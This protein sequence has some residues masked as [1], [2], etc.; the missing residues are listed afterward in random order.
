MGPCQVSAEIA[1]YLLVI[2]IYKYF[3]LSLSVTVVFSHY[4]RVFILFTKK[5]MKCGLPLV[6]KDHFPQQICWL[7][8]NQGKLLIAFT[9][10]IF[11]KLFCGFVELLDRINFWCCLFS[12]L[13]IRH[14][15][16]ISSSISS[17]S[18]NNTFSR[19][20][21]L[22]SGSDSSTLSGQTSRSP[23]K[24]TTWIHEWN[25]MNRLN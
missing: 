18:A 20:F 12:F 4:F 23:S 1:Q 7:W 22:H 15:S 14:F 11:Y 19:T 25:K 21:V 17:S 9:S 6:L 5:I 13:D 3:A 8:K 16:R 2:N 24:W 10:Y